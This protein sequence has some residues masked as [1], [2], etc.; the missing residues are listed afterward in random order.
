MTRRGFTLIELLVVI[1]IIAIL[2][3]I[4]FPVFA[5]AR[6]KARQASCQSNLKQ[7]ALA[8]L[9]YSQDYDETLMRFCTQLP[10]D[11]GCFYKHDLLYAYTKNHQIW[12][13]PSSSNGGGT[14]VGW[15][16]DTVNGDYGY[17]CMTVSGAKM[18]AIGAPSS[19]MMFIECAAAPACPNQSCN[20]AGSRTDWIQNRHNDGSNLAYTDGHVKWQ[21]WS[22]INSYHG[23]G[24]GIYYTDGVDRP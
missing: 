23:L 2:A 4:L 16:A 11:N 24:S 22:I 10:N 6:E 17:P 5:R 12:I 9:M 3:A 19:V 8:N 7:L 18:A 21:K 13:C 20:F 14:P 15:P 1:A